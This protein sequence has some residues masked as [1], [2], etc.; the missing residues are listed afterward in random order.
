MDLKSTIAKWIGEGSLI[1]ISILLAFYL[2]NI[3]ENINRKNELIDDLVELKES[4]ATDT[5][6]FYN[7]AIRAVP[8]ND[9]IYRQLNDSLEVG[10]RAKTIIAL[11]DQTN[12]GPTY[13]NWI[14]E[15][16]LQGSELIELD[17]ITKNWLWDYIT[18]LEF[19]QNGDRKMLLTNEQAIEQ[20]V[21]SG[22]SKNGICSPESLGM[23]RR[24]VMHNRDLLKKMKLDL[25]AH[26]DHALPVMDQLDKK[27]AELS[28]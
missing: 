3:R 22:I 13:R 1:V 19:Y 16:L 5:L 10:V 27:I 15:R 25:L 12:P 20:L 7:V 18:M 24:L 28:K 2:E 21:Y 11:L 14:L 17:R 23:I 4:I 6:V 8:I 9:S 26:A